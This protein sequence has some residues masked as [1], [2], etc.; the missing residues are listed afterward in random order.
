[1]VT[2]VTNRVSMLFTHTERSANLPNGKSALR[3]MVRN[4]IY[5]AGPVYEVIP[6]NGTL[7]MHSNSESS[8]ATGTSSLPATP[9]SLLPPVPLP[10][11][12]IESP[13]A[14]TPNQVD[15]S[16]ANPHQFQNGNLSFDYMVMNAVRSVDGKRLSDE[17]TNLDSDSTRARYVPEPCASMV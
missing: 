9:T 16:Y 13:Y 15:P 3:P 1:M 7:R 12:P 14:Y 2:T 8:N 6:P 4:P 17:E 11:I 10:A 5:D